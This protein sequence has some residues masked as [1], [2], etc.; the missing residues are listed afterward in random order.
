MV[1]SNGE[2]VLRWDG[3]ENS[4]FCVTASTAA[5]YEIGNFEINLY[6]FVLKPSI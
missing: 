5:G 2:C 1:C 4:V 3:V 6:L